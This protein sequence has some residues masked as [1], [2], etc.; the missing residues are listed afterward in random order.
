MKYHHGLLNSR[1]VQ[2]DPRA[3]DVGLQNLVRNINSECRPRFDV[4]SRPEDV[5]RGHEVDS[6]PKLFEAVP[7]DHE[8][9]VGAV[10]RLRRHQPNIEGITDLLAKKRLK[11]PL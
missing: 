5:F 1:W 6:P 4:Q 11:K 9:I 7:G 10:L 8:A 3:F 2:F